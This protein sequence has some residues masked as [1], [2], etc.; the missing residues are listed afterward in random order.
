MENLDPF[1]ACRQW[2]EANQQDGVVVYGAGKKIVRNLEDL[3]TTAIAF[4]KQPLPYLF[5]LGDLDWEGIAIYDFLC[6]H[7]P[8]FSIPLFMEGYRLMLQKAHLY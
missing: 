8:T 3:Q 1:I 5:Y 6:Q 4:L 7:Y 2:L